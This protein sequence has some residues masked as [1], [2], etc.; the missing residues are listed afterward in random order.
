MFMN[1]TKRQTGNIFTDLALAGSVALYMARMI[2]YV[3]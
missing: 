3:L 2:L 1:L